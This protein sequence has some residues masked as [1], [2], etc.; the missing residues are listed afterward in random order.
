MTILAVFL[1]TFMIGFRC[2]MA[3]ERLRL[4]QLRRLLQ[5]ERWRLHKVSQFVKWEEEEPPR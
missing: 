3:F 2:G 5:R 4:D 1:A